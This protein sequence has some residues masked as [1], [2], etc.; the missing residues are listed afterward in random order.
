MA[1]AVRGI[2]GANAFIRFVN[3]QLWQRSF[4][5]A[6]GSA[7]SSVTLAE[8]ALCSPGEALQRLGSSA[9]GL[10]TEEAEERLRSVGPN[11]VAH[12]AR[13]TIAGEI[14]AARSTR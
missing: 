1:S 11:E 14:I 5:S 2:A 4:N 12:E 7:A 8:V 13:H 9:N 10:T 6:A 3:A